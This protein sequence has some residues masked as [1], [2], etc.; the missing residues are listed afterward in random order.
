MANVLFRSLLIAANNPTAAN[1]VTSYHRCKH[2]YRST[3][4]K[5]KP[6]RTIDKQFFKT[7]RISGVPFCALSH[8]SS[9]FDNASGYDGRQMLANPSPFVIYHL[10]KCRLRGIKLWIVCFRHSFAN[11]LAHRK[12]RN[13]TKCLS[14]ILGKSL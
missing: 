12:T 7:N 9:I 4:Y 1:T 13:F 2:C 3:I 11:C 5:R 10:Q 8:E 14:T 6:W